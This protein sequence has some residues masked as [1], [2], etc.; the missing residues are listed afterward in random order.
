MKKPV[1]IA[2]IKE[3]IGVQ[4]GIFHRLSLRQAL[5]LFF[6]MRRNGKIHAQVN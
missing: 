5:C 6:R 3:I 4:C 2:Q 1:N